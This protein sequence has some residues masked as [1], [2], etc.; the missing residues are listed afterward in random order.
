MS[1]N[2][3]NLQLTKLADSENFSNPV[4]N[5]N[6]DKIEAFYTKS[7]YTASSSIATQAAFDNVL[8]TALSS[9]PSNSEIHLRITPSASFG[10][11][12]SGEAYLLDMKKTA[13]T[14]Y[15]TAIITRAGATDVI[16]ATRNSNGWSYTS[17]LSG[18]T[19]PNVIPNNSDL[20]DYKT[21]G[22]S[23][24]VTSSASA[25]TMSHIPVTTSGGRLDVIG[26]YSITSYIRQVY[27]AAGVADIYTRIFT[28]S[29]WTKW[30]KFNTTEVP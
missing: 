23:F 19:P 2:T 7:L 10:L 9:A 26:Q 11:F 13:S 24:I 28:T 22:T 14:T 30:Y 12:I 20:N 3:S 15:S 5:G 1:S 4:L 21:P 17:F 29:T 27:M 18:T 16:K 8:D 25:Q 6:W